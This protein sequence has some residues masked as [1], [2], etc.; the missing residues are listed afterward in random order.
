ML[1]SSI[2][3]LVGTLAALLGSPAQAADWSDAWIGYQF[4]SNM[5]EPGVTSGIQK[6]IVELGYVSADKLG[7]NL[8]IVDNYF[9]NS[10][11]PAAPSNP[12][13]APGEA[14]HGSGSLSVYAVLR[15]SFSLSALSGASLA[16]GPVRD[17]SV[18]G[19]VVYGA[20]NTVGAMRPLKFTLGPTFNFNVTGGFLDVGVW[21]YKEYNHNGYIAEP[22]PS[23]VSFRATYDLNVA[24]SLPLGKY[25][26]FTGYGDVIGPKGP[27]LFSSF[28]G[29][30][31]KTEFHIFPKLMLDAGALLFKKKDFVKVGIGIEIWRNKYGATASTGA[32]SAAPT[33]IAEIHL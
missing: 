29:K 32:N 23:S 6:N 18:T 25:L 27:E 11:Y 15:R 7:T 28:T 17:V 20:E 30:D 13:F 33:V 8:A 16:F 31:A 9:S 14:C 21:L 1:K 22:A 19:G 3:I 2:C 4:Q 10:C 12:P 24:W 5:H 26:S